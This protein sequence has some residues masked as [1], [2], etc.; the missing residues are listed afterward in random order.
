[1]L[2]C[3]EDEEGVNFSADC[4]RVVWSIDEEIVV[5]LASVLSPDDEI[6]DDCLPVDK[7]HF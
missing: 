7:E 6:D 2:F 4:G 5:R 1:M 3:S